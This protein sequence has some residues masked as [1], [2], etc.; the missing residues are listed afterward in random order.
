MAKF[1][2]SKILMWLFPMLLGV[3]VYY[4]ASFNYNRLAQIMVIPSV[5][6][7]YAI[8]ILF[9]RGIFNKNNKSTT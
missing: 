7:L 2:P 9:K 5:L 8:M 4:L 6:G 1:A 3:A